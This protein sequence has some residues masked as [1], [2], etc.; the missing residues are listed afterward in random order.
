[1]LAEATRPGGTDPLTAEAAP[2]LAEV[3]AGQLP[4]DSAVPAYLGRLLL[5][6]GPVGSG[7]FSRLYAMSQDALAGLAR[8]GLADR[9]ADP[10]VRAAFLLLN[11]LA[12]LVLRTRLQEVLGVDPLSTDG[13]RRWGA[14]VLS[15]YAHGLRAPR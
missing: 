14:E 7:L 12:V 5:D 6:G 3:V 2:N 1:M 10:E 9:G 11:D 15:I 8:A 13:M 4:A